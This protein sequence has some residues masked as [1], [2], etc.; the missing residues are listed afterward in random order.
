MSLFD[1]LVFPTIPK[2]FYTFGFTYN[3]MRAFIN[4]TEEAIDASIVAYKDT[5]PS[6]DEIEISPEEGIYQCAYHYQG[7][8]EHMDDVILD[9]VVE[10]YFPRKR[11]ASEIK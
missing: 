6:V 3:L 4:H 9:D 7:L 2:P 11:N 5:G 10:N 1:K 8:Y